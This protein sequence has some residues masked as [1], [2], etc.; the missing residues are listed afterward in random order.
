MN[1]QKWEKTKNNTV[2]GEYYEPVVYP[3][4][5]GYHI[6]LWFDF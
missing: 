5:K 4:F 1:S 6:R 2:T 3:E